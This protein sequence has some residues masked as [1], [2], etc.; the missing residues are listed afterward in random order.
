LNRVLF[1]FSYAHKETDLR[2]RYDLSKLDWK[3]SG[4]A[5]EIWRLH[6]TME[7]GALP[8]A[9]IP[10]IPAKVP[11]SVQYNLR[12]AGLLPDWSLGLNY[13]ECEWV[14]NRHWI[15]E[16]IIPD[17]WIE[18]GKSVRLNC[19]G[20]D[21]SGEVF[22][23]GQSVGSFANS[24]VPHIFDVTEYLSEVN[25]VLRIVFTHSPR[26]L[27]Q[28]G[29]TSRMNEW[30]VRFNYT[31]DW[32]VRLVQIG[33]AKPIFLEVTDG[34]E[35][36]EFCC[37]TDVV[38][39]NTTGILKAFGKA[40]GDL[41]RLTLS[42][43][44]SLVRQETVSVTDFNL[45]G[46]TWQDIPV[47]LWWPNLEGG[48]PLY[49]LHVELLDKQGHLLDQVD[50]RIGFK[51][52]TWEQCEGAP[53]DADPWKCV[54]NGKSVFLQG[55][56]WTPILPNW[57]DV[58]EDQYKRLLIQ[59]RDLGVNILR[60]WGGFT[61][62]AKCFYDLCD[63]LGLMIWQE[64]PLSSSGVDNYPP[65]DEESIQEIAEIAKSFI[66]RRQ[67]HVSLLL[68]CGG[69]ELQ[70]SLDGR[71]TG[72]GKPLDSSH[73]MIATL[74]EVSTTQDPTRRFLPTSASGPRECA[75]PN[76]FG[77]GLH[78]D[79][80]GPWKPE[81]RLDENWNHYWSQL[82]ALFCSETGCPSASP[83]HI[84]RRYAGNLDSM[85]ANASNP[86][87]RRTSPWWI[88]WDQFIAEVGREPKDLE[89]YVEW[90]QERQKNALYIA[91]KSCKERF[92]KCGG[93]LIWM[94]HDCFPCTANTAIIDFEG[95]P[96]PAA[97]ALK[98]IWRG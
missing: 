31:W 85:P 13:R 97:L 33:I 54:V 88:E 80:H 90:S 49:D 38:L 96:K 50:L 16:T 52:V 22:L 87:W 82:D 63:Q 68:W 44:G 42:Q 91:V 40:S 35:I 20:L 67:H 77:Q 62:E 37:F 60:V 98:K 72:G 30:K 78:W 7:I 55:V 4:W 51:H 56:N 8:D 15:Y 18:P 14:E 89:E 1:T 29:F 43:N 47:E 9:E 71:K 17:E 95:N 57:A 58:T 65:E 53:S 93:I 19:R 21:Y 73:P 26:W 61:L 64:F 59:Y 11:A 83:A 39:S 5:P 6:Q 45:S 25:N 81:G 12:N 24:H 23:N 34:Q 10:S 28:F 94:G 41:L 84:I 70:M 75:H 3:L 76:C 2:K 74:E 36:Q 32:V 86:L 66:A 27:G 92:P 48:Q 79:V 69:N 46:T